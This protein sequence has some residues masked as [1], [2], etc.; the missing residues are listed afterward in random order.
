VTEPELLAAIAAHADEDALLAALGVQRP[1]RPCGHCGQEIPTGRRKF[2]SD[3]CNDNAKAL[4]YW[5]RKQQRQQ[6]R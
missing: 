3:R 5:H 2:C 1:A 4:R 6:D